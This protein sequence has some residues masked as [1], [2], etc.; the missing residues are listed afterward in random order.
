MKTDP[1]EY[2]EPHDMV[3]GSVPEEIGERPAYERIES[4]LERYP[5]FD[6]SDDPVNSPVHYTGPVPGVECND[7]TKHFPFNLG[8]VIKYVWRCDW[9]G[10]SIQDLE[11]ALWYLTSEIE[12]RKSN[13]R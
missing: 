12:L 10:N 7:I 11:K 4:V 8:N 9:K 3:G 6:K 5:P 1:K 13:V 2:P